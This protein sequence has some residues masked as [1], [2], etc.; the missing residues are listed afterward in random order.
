DFT[1]EPAL[2]Y[3]PITKLIIV[4]HPSDDPNNPLNGPLFRR[5]IIP[6]A[7]LFVTISYHI[8]DAALLTGY[9]LVGVGVAG[10]LVVPTALICRKHHLFLIGHVLMIASCVWAGASGHNHQSLS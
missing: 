6:A 10:T 9:H 8:W 7:L 2:N 4:P 5:D 3:D 1:S